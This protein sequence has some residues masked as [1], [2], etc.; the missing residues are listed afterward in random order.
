MGFPARKRKLLTY[1]RENVIDKF[2]KPSRL[3]KDVNEDSPLA[4]A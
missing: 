4:H 3:V 1:F 2:K